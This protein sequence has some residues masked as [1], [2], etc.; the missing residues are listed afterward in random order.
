M[1]HPTKVDVIFVMPTEGQPRYRRRVEVARQA[2]FEVR[3]AGFVRDRFVDGI[4][5]IDPEVRL[6]RLRDGRYVRRLFAY[7]KGTLR[8]R[9][10]LP[11]RS[12]V[13]GFGIEAALLALAAGVGRQV[14]LVVEIA[15]IHKYQTSA[16][17]VRGAALR[18]TERLLEQRADVFVVTSDAY[19]HGYFEGVRNMQGIRERAVTMH[20]TPLA[21]ARPNFAPRVEIAGAPSWKRIGYFGLIR[22]PLSLEALLDWVD[23]DP[24]GMLRVAGSL[25]V[26]RALRD[27]LMAT[28]RAIWSGPYRNPD[29]LTDLYGSVSL[30][31]TPY[32]LRWDTPANWQWARTNRYFES[33]SFGV[34]PIA[35][36][37]T[38]DGDEVAAT[39]IGLALEVPSTGWKE[40][41]VEALAAIEPA[42]VGGWRDALDSAAGGIIATGQQE[43]AY[44]D[45]L[46][47]L[48]RPG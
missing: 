36:R 23:S 5:T 38:P 9:Q 22:C 17:G 45:A 20:N 26:P 19:V 2:G 47:S 29:D 14:K 43:R 18:M 30:V 46:E 25:Y 34:P 21:A 40:S 11:D 15:D 13:H 35:R 44:I 6:G 16:R 8:L 32:Q 31:W 39:F 7:M 1:I 28:E 12:V 10:H 48:L 42:Q 4:S 27:R 37:G 3:T 41:I 33:C 24:D